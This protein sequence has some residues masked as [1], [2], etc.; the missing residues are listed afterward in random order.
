MTL[1]TAIEGR[2][3]TKFKE[4]SSVAG[5]TAIVVVNPDGSSLG[6]MGGTGSTSYSHFK[7]AG[8][9][10]TA[11]V[12][13][14]AGKVYSLSCQNTNASL[15]YIQ[16]HD[17]A[18]AA[19]AGEEAKYSFPVYGGTTSIIDKDFLGDNGATFLTGIT[20]AFS[21]TQWTYTAGT[22][23]DQSTQVEYS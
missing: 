8:A 19:S 3:Y 17:K 20:F 4:S 16:L 15:R 21:T 22:A 7:D 18:S 9:N 11:N 14:S 10:A 23:S 6:T 12:K 2:E 1:P 5:Q 13:A